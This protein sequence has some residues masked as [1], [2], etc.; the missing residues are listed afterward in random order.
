MKPEVEKISRRGRS[1]RSNAARRS[2]QMAAGKLPIRFRDMRVMGDLSLSCFAV[3]VK[4]KTRLEWV[5]ACM[6]GEETDT[7]LSRA[8]P[9]GVK[10]RMEM[11]IMGVLGFIFFFV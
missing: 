1:V 3:A 8:L 9:G 10:E 5:G 11:W 6:G 2:G 4:V 7:S